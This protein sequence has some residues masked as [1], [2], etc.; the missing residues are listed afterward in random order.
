MWKANANNYAWT[1]TS[2]TQYK[3][4]DVQIE[5]EKYV[6]NTAQEFGCSIILSQTGKHV[7]ETTGYIGN[8]VK[9]LEPN[10][11]L[12]FEEMVCDF[13]KDESGIWWMI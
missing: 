1:I 3:E 7:E 5:K 4:T 12:S 2:K 9:F 13:I 6:V 8:L 10:M 11:A